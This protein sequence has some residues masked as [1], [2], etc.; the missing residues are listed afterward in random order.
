MGGNPLPHERIRSVESIGAYTVIERV[1]EGGMAVVYRCRHRNEAKAE[2]QGGDVA[3]KVMHPHLALDAGFQARFER[4]ARIGLELEHEG[5]VRV[6]DLVVDQ[7]RLGL[8]LEWIDGEPLDERLARGPYTVDEA[9]KVFE[10]IAR[11]VAHAHETGVV[12]RDLKPQNIL[13]APSGPKVVDFGIAKSAQQASLTRTGAGIGTPWYMAPEQYVQAKGVDA[14]A[15]IYALGMLL[16]EMLVGDLPWP[17]ELSEYEVLRRKADGEL[18][19]GKVPEKLQAA[20]QRCLQPAPD[21]R[22]PTVAVLIGALRAAQASEGAAPKAAPQEVPEK[23]PKPKKPPSEKAA[24]KKAAAKKKGGKG[25][26]LGCLGGLALLV[27][28][29]VGTPTAVT[30]LGV[31][32]P[33]MFDNSPSSWTRSHENSGFKGGGK[34]ADYD[35]L[36][37]AFD[38]PCPGDGSNFCSTANSS[39][40][41]WSGVT[42]L[43]SGSTWEEGVG[44]VE[45]FVRINSGAARGAKAGDI[46]YVWGGESC[47]GNLVRAYESTVGLHFTETLVRGWGC[48]EGDITIVPKG[49]YLEY[50]WTDGW[51]TLEA[52][53]WPL[54]E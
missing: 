50:S 23:T 33:P 44:D 16:A 3:I 39:L 51:T 49:G 28:M 25:W 40:Y 10:P 53:L 2:Q 4:E 12:H 48:N 7:D 5:I 32:L 35:G 37:D 45:V 36:S 47:G 1:G 8:V 43:W 27:C 14:R 29:G 31:M 54:S 46:D 21:A 6:H 17:S 18:D 15:D 11:A 22:W 26:I 30:I 20:I 34:D 38:D 24:P 9:L 13:L 41:S 19:L 52:T 42:G